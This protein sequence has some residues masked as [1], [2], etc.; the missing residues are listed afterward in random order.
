METGQPDEFDVDEFLASPTAA[1]VHDMLSDAVYKGVMKAYW[2]MFM[3]HGLLVVATTVALALY[4][5][6]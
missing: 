1:H 3:I 5:M 6:E 2:T 4:A